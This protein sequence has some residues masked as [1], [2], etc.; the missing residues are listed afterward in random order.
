[1]FLRSLTNSLIEVLV[2]KF[3]YRNKSQVSYITAAQSQSGE[4]QGDDV[5]AA[6]RRD[7][8]ES[9]DIF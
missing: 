8:G 4:S 5:T 2:F 9:S 7:D 1:M 6:L 3:V